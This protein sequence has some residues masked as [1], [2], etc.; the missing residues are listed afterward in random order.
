M[1]I[2]VWRSTRSIG[3]PMPRS[4]TRDNVATSSESLTGSGDMPRSV[5]IA[6]QPDS[7]AWCHRD[8]AP[9]RRNHVRRARCRP[10]AS[11]ARVL[12]LLRRQ[13]PEVRVLTLARSRAPSVRAAG[14]PGKI[15]RAAIWATTVSVNLGTTCS[16]ITINAP[17][18]PVVRCRRGRRAERMTAAATLSGENAGGIARIARPDWFAARANIGVSIGPGRTAQTLIAERCHV[19]WCR[20]SVSPRMAYLLIT[21]VGTIGFG[22]S[23]SSDETLI[24]TPCWREWK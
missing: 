14:G 15:S 9:G 10:T 1:A 19:D 5:A 24:S 4:E 8:S 11:P 6:S 12:Y 22:I 7:D 18:N 13:P 23:P 2:T 17:V 20:L 21:Y 16:P 3:R